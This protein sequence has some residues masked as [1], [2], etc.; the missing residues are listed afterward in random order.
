M[1]RKKTPQTKNFEN[2]QLSKIE[3]QTERANDEKKKI[4]KIQ[5][6]FVLVG[7]FFFQNAESRWQTH[8][9]IC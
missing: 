7:L 3:K 4:Q 1:F 5:T 6:K 2:V 9:K 8:L